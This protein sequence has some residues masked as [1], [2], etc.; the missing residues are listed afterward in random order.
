MRYVLL[1]LLSFNAGYVDAAG[2]LALHGLF[3][4]HVTGNFV[5]LGAS[6]AMGA[7]GVLAKLL[8]LPL[9][10]VVVLVARLAGIGMER[11]GWP[12]TR[13]MLALQ[14]LLLAGAAALAARL[15]PFPDGD[16][17]PALATGGALVAAMAI[18]NAVHR[19]RLASLPPST[20]MTGTTTQVMVDLGDLMRP[21]RPEARAAAKKRL[22]PMALSLLAFAVGC[23]AGALVYVAI[24]IW[25]FVPPPIVALLTIGFAGE[26]ATEARSAAAKP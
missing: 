13:A 23:G 5:T 24:P 19:V 2:F 21:I 14:A 9:F 20:I 3:T 15:G 10:C 26:S 1:V 22:G 7:T 18:Q 6:V 16:A 4:T 8:A 25:C 11:R 17:W 12:V